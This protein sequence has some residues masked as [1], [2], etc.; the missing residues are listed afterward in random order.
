MTSTAN[1]VSPVAW[2]TSPDTTRGF[3]PHRSASMPTTGA[4]NMGMAVQGST[5]IPA[6]SGERPWTVCRNWVRKKIEP[7]IPKLNNMAVTLTE[8]KPRWRK[9]RMSSMG[10]AERSSQTTKVTRATAPMTNEPTHRLAGPPVAV[11]PHQSE[12]DAE[13]SDAD[14]ADP[15]QIETGAGPV[16]LGQ[17]PPGQRGEDDTDGHVQPEDVLPRPSGGDGPAHQGSYGHG[18]TADGA[19]QSEGHIAAVGRDGRTEKGQ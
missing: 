9:R 2:R 7:N 6:A 18:G 19:P 16:G 17:L 8:A 11:A 10:W 14:Q 15:D 13:Q 4:S 5:R 1:Q 3:P 12:D